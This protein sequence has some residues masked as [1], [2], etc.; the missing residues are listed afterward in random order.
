MTTRKAQDRPSDAE[1]QAIVDAA[2]HGIHR[3]IRRRR[4]GRSKP[5]FAAGLAVLVVTGGSA[6][7]A[8]TKLAAPDEEA[9]SD[10]FSA[11]PAGPTAPPKPGED[12]SIGPWT[13]SKPPPDLTPIDLEDGRSGYLRTYDMAYGSQNPAF[14]R[15]V[16][17][18][19]EI[20]LPVYAKDGQ[21]VIGE[22]V[23]GTTS[24]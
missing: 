21:K 3:V 4:M 22:F 7:V 6:A 8:A 2:Q 14:K 13:I 19:F 16:G 9:R 12:V 1:F 23:A 17:R 18:H 10:V 15:K 24:G 5:A 11:F 20:V